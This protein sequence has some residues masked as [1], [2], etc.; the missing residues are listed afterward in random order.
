MPQQ[1]HDI[2]RGSLVGYAIEDG[3]E[4]S[5]GVLSKGNKGSRRVMGGGG[6]VEEGLRGRE[7]RE[8]CSRD[9]QAAASLRVTYSRSIYGPC[10]LI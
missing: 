8:S 7:E 10:I 9:S 4:S 3:D 2:K 6:A 1:W 5:V